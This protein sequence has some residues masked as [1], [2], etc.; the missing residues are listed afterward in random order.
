MAITKTC[1]NSGN[2]GDLYSKAKCAKT[3]K[4]AGFSFSGDIIHNSGYTE[5]IVMTCM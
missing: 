5:E 4:E 2:I 3:F 1:A